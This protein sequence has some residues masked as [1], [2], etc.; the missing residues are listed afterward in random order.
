MD[1][2]SW[3][4]LILIKDK[5]VNGVE[6]L[7]QGLIHLYRSLCSLLRGFTA[8]KSVGGYHLS[9]NGMRRATGHDMG[10]RLCLHVEVRQQSFL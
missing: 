10:G 8:H 6:Q 3:L 9:P 4:S 7:W 1:K 5:R 2:G